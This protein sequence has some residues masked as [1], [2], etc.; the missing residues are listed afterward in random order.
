MELI[1]LTLN[2]GKSGITL[3]MT[4]ETQRIRY[5][6]DNYLNSDD[7]PDSD[8]HPTLIQEATPPILQQYLN[9]DLGD[10]THTV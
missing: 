4:W 3:T 7:F 9:F 6:S 2:M 10:P 8:N 1:K 5:N